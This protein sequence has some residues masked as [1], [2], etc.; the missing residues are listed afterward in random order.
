MTTTSGAAP[1]SD[2][3]RRG[4]LG[5]G[6]LGTLA[7]L[8]AVHFGE[9]TRAWQA[10]LVNVLFFAGLA[11][12]GVVVSAIMQVTS[13]HWGRALKRLAEATSAFLPL[14]GGLLLVLFLG[15]SAWAPWVEAP[16]AAK[17]PWLN[18]PFF[19]TRHAL[20]F[21]GLTALGL[22]YVYCSLRPDIG[23][24]DE[25][26]QRPASGAARRLIAG[27]RGVDAERQRNQRAQDI[28][29]PCLLIAY[30]WV[31]SLIGFDFVMALDPHWFSTL[32]G[33]YYF[34]GNLLIGIAFLTGAAVWSRDRLQLRH[35]I[36]DRQLHD[37]GKLL[38]GFSVLW[39]YMVWSQ[40][41][42]IWY[43]D[44]PEETAFVAHRMDGPWAVITWTVVGLVFAVPFVVLLSRRIKHHAGGIATVAGVV[45]L[46]MWLER[47]L[48][49][50]PSIW[51]GE[52]LPLGIVELLVTLGVAALF[53][54][55]Y[56]TFLGIFPALPFSDPRL[57]ALGEH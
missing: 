52:T 56:T 53:A 39:A 54:W 16:V 2:R 29:A 9:A 43:G 11:H 47:F 35:Y 40:Y 7:F 23:M 34:M 37:I 36:G 18:V 38:F 45:L 17:T 4:L 25:S 50:A 42:V 48:L 15:I 33:A 30:A 32:A 28:L 6:A 5:C 8:H 27:W 51:H 46:G 57:T 10:L 19:V 12:A 13:A 3:A 49:V 26:G 31:F 20:A 22:A 24:L 55:C 14:G 21:I 41:L 1:V 44:L